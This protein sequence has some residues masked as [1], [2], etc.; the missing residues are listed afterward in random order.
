MYDTISAV[1]QVNWADLPRNVKLCNPLK[2][3]LLLTDGAITML[4]RCPYRHAGRSHVVSCKS[5]GFGILLPVFFLPAWL[6]QSCQRCPII[7][8]SFKIRCK[9]CTVWIAEQRQYYPSLNWANQENLQGYKLDIKPSPD[10]HCEALWRTL[11]PWYWHNQLSRADQKERPRQ[12]ARADQWY[13]KKWVSCSRSGQLDLSWSQTCKV[14]MVSNLYSSN[15]PLHRTD[16]HS[17]T[18]SQKFMKVQGSKL[19]NKKYLGGRIAIVHCLGS[20]IPQSWPS[21]WELLIY[22]L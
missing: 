18:Q 11:N 5:T 10:C 3:V 2:L 14:A 9:V 8:L 7:T 19:R 17:R 22:G 20:G 6:A 1:L 4:S 15:E 12:A 13:L 21:C 16:L